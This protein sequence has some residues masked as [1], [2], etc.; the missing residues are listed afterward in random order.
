VLDDEPLMTEYLPAAH[1][2]QSDSA[3]LPIEPRYVPG[4]QSRHDVLDDEPLMTEYL[5]AAHAM[6]SDSASLAIVSRYVPGGQ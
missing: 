3:S 2:M 6:Q 1:A 4:G 5:P